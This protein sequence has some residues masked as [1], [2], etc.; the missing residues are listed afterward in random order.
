MS[1]SAASVANKASSL[2]HDA[3]PDQETRD[4]YLFG[5]AALAVAAAVGIAIQRRVQHDQ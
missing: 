3:V 4:Q 5:V 2:L 1:D